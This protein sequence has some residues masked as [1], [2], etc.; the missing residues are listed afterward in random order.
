MSTNLVQHTLMTDRKTGKMTETDWERERG[1]T[2]WEIQREQKRLREQTKRDT[3]RERQR[4]RQRQGFTETDTEAKGKTV[5]DR[6][7]QRGRETQTDRQMQ[8]AK[9]KHNKTT[10][11]TK[12]RARTHTNNDRW[13]SKS[14]QSKLCC[15]RK[16]KTE[17]R[18]QLL[19]SFHQWH[20]DNL[21]HLSKSA[22]SYHI[23][24]HIHTHTWVIF[25]TIPQDAASQLYLS[26]MVRKSS[27]FE[28]PGL[29]LD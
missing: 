28:S 9:S 15:D 23:H 21:L 2:E 27:G 5:R 6:D 7:R 12:H 3:A 18:Q 8:R 22:D 4:K 1:E 19:I 25:N 14:I 11:W 24:T 13:F 26:L 16:E 17:K 29:S 10:S 20:A